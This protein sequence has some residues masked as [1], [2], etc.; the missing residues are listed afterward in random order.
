MANF[1][2]LTGADDE[3]VMVNADHIVTLA[4]TNKTGPDGLCLTFVAL[5][6][7]VP[8]FVTESIYDIVEMLEPESEV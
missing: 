2:G 6:N 1:I 7:N 8:L 3:R 5:T 4:T